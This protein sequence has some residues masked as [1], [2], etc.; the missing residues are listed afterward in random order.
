MRELGANTRA[1]VY[2]WLI[3]HARNVENISLIK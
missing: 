2:L 3:F 1:Q